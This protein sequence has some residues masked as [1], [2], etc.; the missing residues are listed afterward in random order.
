VIGEAPVFERYRDSDAVVAHVTQT[1]GPK[2]SKQFLALAK[3]TAVRSLQHAE[4][5]GSKGARAFQP[6][7]YDPV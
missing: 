1:F 3:E 5:G 7:L 6:G 4:R 2:F